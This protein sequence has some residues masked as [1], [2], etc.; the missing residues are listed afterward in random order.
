MLCQL[1]HTQNRENAKFC[2]N[3]RSPLTEQT[4]LVDA[5]APAVG[6]IT[7]PG[8]VTED[9]VAHAQSSSESQEPQPMGRRMARRPPWIRTSSANW[10]SS[11]GNAWVGDGAAVSAMRG[12]PGAKTA[13]GLEAVRA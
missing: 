13:A 1:C 3:C 12:L 7:Q 9:A 11:N 4:S 6:R 10:K 2:K 5:P 8:P